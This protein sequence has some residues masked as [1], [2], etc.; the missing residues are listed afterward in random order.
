MTALIKLLGKQID[1]A[2]QDGVVDLIIER[3]K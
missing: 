2:I 3:I 1:E